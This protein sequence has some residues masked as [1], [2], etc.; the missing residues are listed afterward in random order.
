[1]SSPHSDTWSGTPGPADGAQQDRVVRAQRSIPS[2]GIIAPSSSHRR[3]DQSKLVVREVQAVPGRHRVEH[4]AGRRGDL[5]PDAVARD[6]RD[7]LRHEPMPTT[8]TMSGRKIMMRIAP[9][10]SKEIPD[11]IIFVIGTTPE[12]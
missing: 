2:A 4:R 5:D 11:R 6:D 12:P 1:M 10:T 3:Q 7:P 9:I 8:A